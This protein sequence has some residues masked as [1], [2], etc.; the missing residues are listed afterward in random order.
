M[1]GWEGNIQIL[2]KP[3]DCSHVSKTFSTSLSLPGAWFPWCVN[4]Y[5]NYN[6]ANAGISVEKL[7][8]SKSLVFL[9]GLTD[10]VREITTPAPNCY[11]R[12]ILG[13]YRHLKKSWKRG[14]NS[15]QRKWNFICLRVTWAGVKCINDL[16]FCMHMERNLR[17]MD[18]IIQK[19]W[20]EMFE[21]S[22]IMPGNIPL[23]LVDWPILGDQHWPS[24]NLRQQS[25]ERKIHIFCIWALVFFSMIPFPSFL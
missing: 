2:S 19:Q 8:R 20:R 6:M 22:E 4:C 9:S 24:M 16:M 17:W 13:L 15:G 25:Q 1:V 11:L 7:M 3:L 21:I 10:P 12:R 23:K 14:E 5:K 18:T